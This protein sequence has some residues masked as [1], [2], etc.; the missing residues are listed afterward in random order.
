M[1]DTK[2]PK[3]GKPKLSYQK[4]CNECIEKW[5]RKLIKRFRR[6]HEHHN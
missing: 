1:T 2:C 4:H 6:Q 5:Y 3:C